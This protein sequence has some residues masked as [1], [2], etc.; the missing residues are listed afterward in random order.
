MKIT[1]SIHKR[2]LEE[3]YDSIVDELAAVIPGAKA[4]PDYSQG[5]LVIDLPPDA[6][7]ISAVETLRL[8]FAKLGVKAKRVQ[9][10]E[11]GSAPFSQN[12]P[13]VDLGLKKQRTVRLSVFILSLISVALIVSILAFS[14]GMLF[15]RRV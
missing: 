12:M 6:D 10:K 7:P 4:Q 1:F 15:G 9:G 2:R 8:C 11:Q 5:L 3:Q 14:V 13:Q